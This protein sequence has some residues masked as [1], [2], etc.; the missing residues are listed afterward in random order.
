MP[1]SAADHHYERQLIADARITA[2]IE[3]AIELLND[4]LAAKTDRAQYYCVT[5][6]VGKL[7]ELEGGK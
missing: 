3:A 2:T 5:E 6:A 4:A 1:Y 7:K